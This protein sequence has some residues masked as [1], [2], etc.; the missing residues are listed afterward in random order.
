MLGRLRHERSLRVVPV[1]LR[2]SGTV[3][4]PAVVGA[5]SG[6][7]ELHAVSHPP[8]IA[9]LPRL[10]RGTRVGT[11]RWRGVGVVLYMVVRDAL[12]VVT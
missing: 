10:P 9:R 8:L 6:F 7:D 1:K 3:R 11:R 4:R 2:R 12:H 5:N